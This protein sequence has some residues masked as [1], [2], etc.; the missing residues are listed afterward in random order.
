MTTILLFCISRNPKRD[1]IRSR[2]VSAVIF[3]N[4]CTAITAVLYDAKISVK[5]NKLVAF[6]RSLN[7]RPPFCKAMTDSITLL[8][9]EEA[10]KSFSQPFS[11]KEQSDAQ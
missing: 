6:A 8:Q 5:K 1:S 2:N 9:S 11:R 10:N 7:F 3:D 4:P